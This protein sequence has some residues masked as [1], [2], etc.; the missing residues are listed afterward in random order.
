M[1]DGDRFEWRL[2]GKGWRKL[3]RL[4]NSGAAHELVVDQAIAGVASY[5]R[6]HAQ[7]PYAA[8]ASAIFDVLRAP[9]QFKLG[10]ESAL[11]GGSGL[12]NHLDSLVAASEFSEAALLCHRSAWKAFLKMHGE[13]MTPTHAAV[14]ECFAGEL[15]WG[16]VERRCM[17]IVRDEVVAN[18]HRGMQDQLAVEGLLQ[19]AVSQR[20]RTFGKHFIRGSDAARIRAPRSVKPRN[21]FTEHDLHK[22]LPI[23]EVS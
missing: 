22:L 4:M 10:I 20:G 23:Q 7:T 8:F 3:Y 1:P 21:H 16:I 9:T 13:P 14:T 17:G 19:E 6:D 11:V 12:P 2:K 15:S 5:L 18:T